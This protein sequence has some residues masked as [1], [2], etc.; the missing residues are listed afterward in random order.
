[1]APWRG[2][3]RVSSGTIKRADVPVSTPPRLAMDWAIDRGENYCPK[4]RS[5]EMLMKTL[6]ARAPNCV[7]RMRP[8]MRLGILQG[9]NMSERRSFIRSL[10]RRGQLPK[11]N[12][13]II[14]WSTTRLRKTA[15]LHGCY[16]F[17]PV[18]LGKSVLTIYE[19]AKLRY[20]YWIFRFRRFI[21]VLR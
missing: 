12:E 4:I 6:A 10:L 2:P 18:A 15:L 1:M 8:A 9:K 14:Q 20:S 11:I 17:L 7:I 21:A 19:S 5:T 16:R 13:W 3:R